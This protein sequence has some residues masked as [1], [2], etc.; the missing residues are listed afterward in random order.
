MSRTRAERSGGTL[1]ATEIRFRQIVEIANEGIWTVD[2]D[3]RID[4]VN[5]RLCELFGYAE[6]EM[7]GRPFM[8]FMDAEARVGVAELFERRK[9]GVTEQS[10][11]RYRRKDG[12]PL[13]VISAATPFLDDAGVFIG[14]LAMITDIGDRKRAEGELAETSRGLAEAIRVLGELAAATG[15]GAE[16]MELAA[17]KCQAIC[18]ADGAIVAMVDGEDLVAT[19]ASGMGEVVRGHR[20]PRQGTQSDTVIRSGRT[21]SSADCETDPQVERNIARQI[22]IRSVIVAALRAESGPIGIVTVL[23][24]RPDAFKPRDVANLEIL[25]GSVGPLL[26]RRRAAE[27]MRASEEEYRLLFRSNPQPMWVFDKTTL[28]FLAVNQAATR[29]YGWS[30]SEF[31]SRTIRDIQPP[32]DQDRLDESLREAGAATVS[33]VRHTKRDGSTILV[34]ITGDDIVFQ[35]SKARL[36][37]AT[38][39]TARIEAEQEQR[40]HQQQFLRAQRMESL[41]TLAGGIAHDLNNVLAP[42]VLS[43]D[44]LRDEVPEGSRDLLDTVGESAKRAAE[45]VRQVVSFARGMEG[46]RIDVQFRDLMTDLERIV[47]ETFPKNI[48]I[49]TSAP[50]DLWPVLGD[51]AQL[52]QV[53]RNL[54]A[55][56]R[57]AMPDGGHLHLVAQN[58]DID[59]QY[60]AKHVGA[61]VGPHVV[62]CVKDSGVGIPTPIR[63]RIFDPFFTTKEQGKGTGLGLSTSLAIVKSHG[64]FLR[65]IANDNG[66]TTF[67]VHLPASVAADNPTRR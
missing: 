31:L 23:S 3:G 4:F 67:E 27:R 28:R 42:I 46:Q 56:A 61:T 15:N 22:G 17:T 8:D 43:V 30:E 5:R 63:D 58:R 57:D 65:V 40:A 13:W 29:H 64:G 32:D 51:A 47:A 19:S 11:I 54:S 26:Q 14:A 39:V 49:H 12:S 21:F 6:D 66:G 37:A 60:A 9:R 62:I 36:V 10:E 55:N 53:L 16:L 44:L 59:A 50:D 34:D 45:M 1:D 20:S 35:G 52:H 25:V 24:R 2:R 41:G 7:L 38:D 18:S 33:A 48:T